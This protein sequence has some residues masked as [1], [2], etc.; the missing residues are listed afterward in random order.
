ME[1][2][3]FDASFENVSRDQRVD[4]NERPRQSIENHLEGFDTAPVRLEFIHTPR[5]PYDIPLIHLFSISSYG[6]VSECG[7]SGNAA[8]MVVARLT[9]VPY[10]QGNPSRILWTCR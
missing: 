1:R 7:A 2:K 8:V 9:E 4:C 6:A 10:G 3:A 5:G